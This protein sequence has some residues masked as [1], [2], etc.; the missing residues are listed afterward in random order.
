[1]YYVR[2]CVAGLYL[3]F[4]R[5]LIGIGVFFTHAAYHQSCRDTANTIVYHYCVVAGLGCRV[6]ALLLVLL[7][8]LVEVHSQ[9]VPYVSF[10]GENLPN[11]AFV[12]LSLVGDAGDGSDSVQCHTDL[13][14]CCSGAQGADRGDWYFPSGVR[15]QFSSSADNI[16]ESRTAQR[17]DLRHENNADMPSGI[18]RCDIETIAVRSDNEMDMTTRETVYAGIYATGGKP[19]A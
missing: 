1:M 18:Y 11:H 17:V 19:P 14:T 9:T 10:M 13:Q 2:M 5:S 6:S 4:R 8:S 16:Y 3:T 12:N 15:L 7:W